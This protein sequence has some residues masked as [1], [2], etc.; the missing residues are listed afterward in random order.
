MYKHGTPVDV[1]HCGVR[2][3]AGRRRLLLLLPCLPLL[4]LAGLRLLA[5][6]IGAVCLLIGTGLPGVSEFPA[7]TKTS[8]SSP[9]SMLHRGTRS[10]AAHG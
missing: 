6:D 3:M 1:L 10:S 8:A 9:N 4:L 5:T 2:L 7:P